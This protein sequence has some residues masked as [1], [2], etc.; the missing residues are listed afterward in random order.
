LTWDRKGQIFGE[1]YNIGSYFI[2]IASN[3]QIIQN[4]PNKM[5]DDQISNFAFSIFAYD[6]IR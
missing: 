6:F 2:P 3:A 4:S 1:D 5:P